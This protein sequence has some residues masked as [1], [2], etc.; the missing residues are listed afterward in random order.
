M[1]NLAAIV[2]PTGAGKSSIAVKVGQ[3]LDIEVISCDSMQIYRGMDVG[4]AKITRDEMRGVPHHM[5]DICDPD[6][7]FSVSD[8]QKMVKPLIKQINERGRIPMLV[9]GTGLYYQVVVDDYQLY[10]IKATPE[11]RQA[12]NDE[13]GRIG[14]QALHQRLES[15]DPETAGKISHNDR[16]RIIRALEVIEVTGQPFSALQKRNPGRYRLAVAGL[17][18]PRPMLYE[19]L[20]SRLDTMLENGLLEEVKQLLEKG[21]VPGQNSMQ[22]LGYAQIMKYLRGELTW[23]EVVDEIKRDTRRYAKRQLTW[24]RRDPRINWWELSNHNVED[25]FI[26]KICEYIRRNL[27]IDCRIG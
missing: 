8:Y 7:K 15:L 9:G 12:L 20:D 24:F 22:A 23:E 1:L 25:T 18:M 10:P 27:I 4:T 19:R 11:I 16:K 5:I 2:G 6:E 14:N 13:A 3:I 26:D 17:T 21:Y